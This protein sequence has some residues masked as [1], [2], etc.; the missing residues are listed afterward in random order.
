MDG[1]QISE[2]YF[3]KFKELMRKKVG[4]EEYN[5]MI[6]QELFDSATKLI[7]LMGA[8]ERHINRENF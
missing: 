6:E 2:K 3:L 4:E 1:I 5:K 8:V 7:T